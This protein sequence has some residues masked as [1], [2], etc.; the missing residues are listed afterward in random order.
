MALTGPLVEPRVNVA[1]TIPAQ[2]NGRRLAARVSH[3]LQQVTEVIEENVASGAHTNGLRVAALEQR[4]AEQIGVSEVVATASGS[5]ALRAACELLA[6]PPG[7]EVIVPAYTFVMTA[8]AISDA[9]TID[10]SNFT[11]GKCGLTPVFVDVD[12]RTFTI[13]PEQV[14]LAISERTRAIVAV[15]LAGQMADMRGLLNLAAEYDLIVIED[16]AQAYGATFLD[17]GCGALRYAGGVGHMGCFSLSDVK[18]VGSMGGDGGALSISRR[19]L[20]RS[21]TLAARARAWRNTGRTGGHRYRHGE[22]GIRARLDEYSAAECL[23]ELDLFEAWN[24]RR[25]TIADRY[26]R[27]L[28]YGSLEAPFVAPGRG[29]VFFNYLVKAPDRPTR[30]RFVATLLEA[31]IAVADS[32][33]SIP[34]QPV[35][36]EGRLP[37]RTLEIE[38]TRQLEEL[39]VPIP[40]YPELTEAEVQRIETALAEFD[41]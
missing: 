18:N 16:A 37:A 20:E 1:A 28:E 22:W 33:T 4:I 34:D 6:L 35:Y 11:F 21:P 8:Y 13:D 7:S 36:Q 39:L 32:Y 19:I 30:D 27:A 5:A 24:E 41:S 9:M 10:P 3:I 40:C 38:V 17:L 12:P 29:H 25:R 2:G 23:A 31:G 26:S 14:R 15:H